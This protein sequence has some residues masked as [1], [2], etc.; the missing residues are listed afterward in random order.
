[1]PN[2]GMTESMD[3][4]TD[5]TEPESASLPHSAS[6]S[7]KRSRHSSPSL[8][9]QVM[10]RESANKVRL[11]FT[12]AGKSKSYELDPDYAEDLGMLL[13]KAARIVKNAHARDERLRAAEMRHAA[14]LAPNLAKH[15]SE[16]SEE[17]SEALSDGS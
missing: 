15:M 4:P 1:M 12:F 10:H 8:F 17:W 11:T 9:T 13:I 14:K 5:C 6:R 7:K 2:T 16:V 3:T